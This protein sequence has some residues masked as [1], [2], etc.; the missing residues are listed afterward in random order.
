MPDHAQH[1]PMLLAPH[2]LDM[3]PMPVMVLTAQNAITYANSAAEQF[4]GLGRERL[5]GRALPDLLPPG[6]P[7]IQVLEHTR[8]KGG[9]VTE[10]S[11]DLPIA[12]GRAEQVADLYATPMVEGSG[13]IM[14]IIQPRAMMDKMTRHLTH[15]DS[16]RSVGAMASMLAHEIKNPLSGIRGAAQLL[17]S[18]LPEVDKPLSHLIRSEVDRIVRLVE[19]FEIFSDGRPLPMSAVNIYEVLDHVIRLA[20][21]GFAQGITFRTEYDPSLPPI[22]GNRDKLV[23]VLLNLVKNAAEAFGENKTDARITL[24]TAFRPGVS[25]L[26][27]NSAQRVALPFELCIMDNGAGIP[28]HLMPH[29][30]EPF[31]TSKAS[32]TG[33]GLALV[34]KVISDHGGVVECERHKGQTIFRLLL[35]I[36][37]DRAR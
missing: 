2:M 12:K 10:Y 16:A 6:S 32:G 34:A 8:A 18:S 36:H 13:A 30:F 1:N 15:R 20:S 14:L 27:P 22:Q 35:P 28:D 31:V 9:S 17:E 4:L 23:Q 29:L 25:V 26:I 3:M 19:R 7:L 33:L 37:Q 5:R 21:T 11:L 24:T